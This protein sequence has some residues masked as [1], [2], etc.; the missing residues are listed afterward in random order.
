MERRDRSSRM[1]NMIDGD[2]DGGE[3]E[4]PEAPESPSS[5]LHLVAFADLNDR[6]VAD[7]EPNARVSVVSL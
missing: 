5:A 2:D 1:T 4:V 6:P 3:L 7:F